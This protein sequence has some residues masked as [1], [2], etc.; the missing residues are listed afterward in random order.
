MSAL[1]LVPAPSVSGWLKLRLGAT[2]STRVLRWALLALPA[3]SL[4]CTLTAA[5]PSAGRVG[6][7]MRQR[8]SVPTVVVRVWL[9]QLMLMLR[10][11]ASLLPLRATPAV[12]SARLTRSS[13]VTAS[14][15]RVGAVVSTLYSGLAT[16]AGKS[17]T[18]GLP[19]ASWMLAP[20]GNCKALAARATPALS[21]RP[22][23]MVA[24]I[25]QVFWPL[26]LT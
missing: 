6:T 12:L 24:R 17:S 16:T 26:P 9:P 20:A 14:R 10:P 1:L 8:P 5:L 25:T 18:A 4:N 3:A 19:A 11:T 15:V 2:V 13:P 22:L 7:S 21:F 23:A